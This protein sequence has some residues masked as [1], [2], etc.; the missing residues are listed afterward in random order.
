M[1]YV[2]SQWARYL[3]T[4]ALVWLFQC[5]NRLAKFEE[6]CHRYH[7]ALRHL[8]ERCLPA[9]APHKPAQKEAL[10]RLPLP[11]L[12]HLHALLWRQSLSQHQG[13]CTL[14]EGQTTAPDKAFQALLVQEELL[15][16]Q[17]EAWW[18]KELQALAAQPGP[19]GLWSHAL[20]QTPHRVD[21]WSHL[22][23]HLHL[24]LSG[25]LAANEALQAFYQSSTLPWGGL[26]AALA[27]EETALQ[28]QWPALQRLATGYRAFEAFIDEPATW[29]ASPQAQA[30]HAQSH[31]LR[32]VRRVVLVEGV[33]E[34][35][36]LPALAHATGYTPAAQG[37]LVL[38][39][40]GKQAL[41]KQYQHLAT[42]FGGEL[43]L[44][45]DADAQQEAAWLQSRLCRPQH[46]MHL[47][48]CGELEDLYPP[49]WVQR[50]LQQ[51]YQL[52]VATEPL[53]LSAAAH[54]QVR[55]SRVLHHWLCQQGVGALDK[56]WLAKTLAQQAPE[57]LA[58]LLANPTVQQV[59]AFCFQ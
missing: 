25:P 43:R 21:L 39:A 34:Q 38:S 27:Q 14:Q 35:H 59:L 22:Q 32:P 23:H 51:V 42:W 57:A 37:C 15:Q 54:P 12:L 11:T 53:V 19:L 13:L 6:P 10:T 18:H 8:L 17:A 7:S 36:L 1:A 45:L 47:L 16:C 40:G 48:P 28:A 24:P 29:L 4:P 44:L 9:N 55:L 5:A 33:S 49:E 31:R 20:L 56:G 30:L 41:V 46:A 50:V 52:P 58:P 3:Q 2:A 26:F